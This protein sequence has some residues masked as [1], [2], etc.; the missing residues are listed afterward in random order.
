MI[1]EVSVREMPDWL[2]GDKLVFD[3]KNILQNSLYYPCCG[4]DGDPIKY[5]AGNVHSFIYVDYGIKIVKFLTEMKLGLRGYHIQHEEAILESQITPKG[6]SLKVDLDEKEKVSFEQHRIFMK[7]PFA[8]WVVYERER[9]FTLA[10]GPDRLSFFFICGDG[11]FT[12]QAT[13]LQHEIVPDI[14]AVIQPGHGYGGN[15]TN[16]YDNEKVFYKSVIYRDEA[17]FYPNYLITNNWHDWPKYKNE[18]KRMQG[19]SN[20]HGVKRY[21]WESNYSDTLILW[22]LDKKVEKAKSK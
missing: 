2:K 8:H 22:E 4:F 9:G 21:S 7:R 16:Y 15:Y 17:D 14:I 1:P 3:L 13:Y 18:I 12:Y 19:F 10:H 11:A 5:F 6:W 20:N